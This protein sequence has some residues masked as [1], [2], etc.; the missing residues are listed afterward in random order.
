MESPN[1][2]QVVMDMNHS[3]AVLALHHFNPKIIS[4][5]LKEMFL[6]VEDADLW[7]W[8]Y[9][10][11][12]AFY[13]GINCFGLEFDAEKNSKIFEEILALDLQQVIEKGCERQEYLD[14][15]IN[16]AAQ[17]ESMVINIGGDAGRWGQCLGLKTSNEDLINSRS[18][19]GNHLVKLSSRHAGEMRA[20]SVVAYFVDPDMEQRRQIKLSFR[21]S[22]DEDTTSITEAFGG[23]GHRNASSCIIDVAKFESWIV[24]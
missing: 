3:G 11:S 23:G 8:K 22:G 6:L 17:Q 19:L 24:Q 9:P 20:M 18:Q 5:D 10:H 13:V 2:L 7:R 16:T 12:K 14:N 4:E 15:L 21:S 1:N